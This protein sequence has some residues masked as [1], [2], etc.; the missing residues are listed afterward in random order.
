MSLAFFSAAAVALVATA[1]TVTRRHAVHAL[2]WFIVSLFAVAVVF[3]LLGAPFA[4]ALEVIVYAGA[5]MVL[6]LFVVMMLNP[7]VAAARRLLRPRAWVVPGLLSA[8]LAAEMVWAVT[9]GGF[10]R[11]GGTEAL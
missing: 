8:L 5:I 3:F 11:G 10:G 6:F 2:L 1:L 7:G 4:A 9:S